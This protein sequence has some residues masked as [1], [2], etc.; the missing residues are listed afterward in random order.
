MFSFSLSLFTL[1]LSCLLFHST[2]SSESD[3]RSTSNDE[4]NV[5]ES[6][7]MMSPDVLYYMAQ[8]KEPNDPEFAFILY[9]I[10]ASKGHPHSQYNVGHYYKLGRG[11]I[12]VNKA[13]ALVYQTISAEENYVPSMMTL[14]YMYHT[15]HITIKNCERAAEYYREL[16]QQVITEVEQTGF[17]PTVEIAKLREDYDSGRDRFA[18]ES[19]IVEYYQ[20]SADTGDLSAQLTMGNLHLQGSYGVE[21]DFEKA[22]QYYKMAEERGEISSLTSIGFMYQQGYY[23]E[24]N[25]K[26]AV[27]YYKKASDQG[28]AGGQTRLAYMYLYGYGVHQSYSKALEYFKSA[29]DQRSHE[30]QLYLGLMYLNGWGVEKSYKSAINFLSLSAHQGNLIGLYHIAN[31]NMRGQGFQQSCPNSVAYYKRIAE[32]GS[33]LESMTK[34]YQYFLEGKYDESLI[35]YEKASEMGFEKAQSNAGWMYDNQF[36]SVLCP[37]EEERYKKALYFYHLA[38]TQNNIDA[39]VR[40]GDYYYYGLGTEKNMEKA[41]QYY[42]V[43]SSSNHAQALFNLAYMHQ[44]G[45]GLSKDLFLAKRYYDLTYEVSS[46]GYLPSMIALAGLGIHFGYDYLTGNL[47]TTSPLVDQDLLLIAILVALLFCLILRRLIISDQLD[48]NHEH[49]D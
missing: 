24:Q 1:L 45:E 8:E 48:G 21:K 20:Y 38:A 9:N 25:N 11:G 40:L 34:A 33:I 28:Y 6:Y 35:L 15:G 36:C 16:A 13:K 12:P 32:R 31:M 43:A 22:Y 46:D 17:Q 14:G 29:A 2:I 10:S 37:N 30:A 5:L 41:V 44:H 7:K 18:E 23:V 4:S 3:E 42:R 47:Q 27:E 19:D 39:T 49:Q 26:T